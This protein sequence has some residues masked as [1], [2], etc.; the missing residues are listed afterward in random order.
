MALT[1][2]E[3]IGILKT[4]YPHGFGTPR[5]GVLAPS[6]RATLV[7]TDKFRDQGL[8]FGLST[9]S[10]VWLISYLDRAI[11]GH[12]GKVRP[13]RLKGQKIGVLASRSPHR[14]NPIGLTVAKIEQVLENSLE[15]SG[16]DLLDGTP[17]LD[18]K[19][20]LSYADAPHEDPVRGWPSELSE[21]LYPVR[22]SGEFLSQVNE[23]DLPIP[24][25]QF[26]SLITECLCR[27]PRPRAYLS[28]KDQNYVFTLFTWDIRF[29]LSSDCVEVYELST[30]NPNLAKVQRVRP[31]KQP[32]PRNPR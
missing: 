28:R 8:F 14:P 4:C 21:D 3:I 7:L 26:L 29:R 13:P 9:F 10:H 20:Y 17:I 22:F 27:D 24:R 25:S 18:V 23:V 31:S 11:T 5:Q 16:V 6:S 15:I 2:F 19:P 32:A 1:A 12:K 30:A